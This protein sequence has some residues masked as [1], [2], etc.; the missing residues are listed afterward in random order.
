MLLLLLA[1][2]P[3]LLVTEALKIVVFAPE[4]ANSQIIWNRRV[5]EE[6]IKAGHDVTLIMISAMD[7]PKPEIKFGPEIKV[8]KIN[9]SVPLNIDFEESMKNSAFLNLPM[10]DVRVRKQFAHFGSALVGSCEH[11][12]TPPKHGIPETADR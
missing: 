12:R 2:L 7:F 11:F 1:V 9:A 8:W 5:C 4:Q 6:L 3:F 10:W